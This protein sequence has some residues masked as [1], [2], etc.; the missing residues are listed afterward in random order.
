MT[1]E[2]AVTN[3]Q[4]K[5]LEELMANHVASYIE[6]CQYMAEIDATGKL[7]AERYSMD[8]SEV[9]KRIA[10]GQDE[11]FKK[12]RNTKLLPRSTEV[13]YEL[14]T[15]K[16]PIA[17]KQL[18]GPDTTQAVMREY[19]K[20]L[21]DPHGIMEPDPVADRKAPPRSQE[22]I[23][24]GDDDDGGGDSDS[25]GGKGEG[26]DYTTYPGDVTPVVL[27][28]DEPDERALAFELIGISIDRNGKLVVGQ[29]VLLIIF[30]GL[31]VAAKGN[32]E[33]LELLK[34]AQEV[35]L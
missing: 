1:T 20:Q 28:P 30:K 32:D 19:K 15:I 24:V 34:A 18:A 17:F 26:I 16:D 22:V 23:D 10:I 35:L 27:A 5:K 29:D 7:I 12:F 14:T 25:D 6:I 31:K 9:S 11:R 3:A 8:K 21:S 2:V 4:W 33:R 13:L